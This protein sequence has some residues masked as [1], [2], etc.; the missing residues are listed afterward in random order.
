MQSGADRVIRQAVLPGQHHKTL[1]VVPPEPVV[2]GKPQ[3]ARVV[4][5]NPPALPGN[6]ALFRVKG[7]KDISIESRNPSGAPPRRTAREPDDPVRCAV[8]GRN[9]AAG[10]AVSPAI[11][12]EVRS[13]EPH[14]ADA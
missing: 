3:P 1:P 4:A 5:N 8:N 14:R 9:G 6:P 13:I 7:V 11:A 12:D 2:A 10:Q